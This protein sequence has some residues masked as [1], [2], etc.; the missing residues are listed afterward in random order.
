MA[1]HQ[2]K[3]IQSQLVS[4][5]NTDNNDCPDVDSDDEPEDEESLSSSAAPMGDDTTD[6]QR[7]EHALRLA[8]NKISAAYAHY[9]LPIL[10]DQLDKF[11][12]RM[13]A[14]KCKIC[15][16]FTNR[17][18]YDSSC[19]N[20]LSHVAQCEKKQQKSSKHKT[21]ASLGVSGTGDIDPQEVLQRCAVWCA[22]GAKPFSALEETSLKRVLHPTILKHLPDR[23]MVSKAIHMLYL[24]VQEKLC[25]DL[26]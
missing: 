11:K 15:L 16:K 1:Q 21:L 19:S 4:E 22:E 25:E 26:K 24:C 20:L 18:A 9:E 5:D 23:K 7:L 13:I 8:H 10:S 14:W 3:R 6:E 17:P 12:R 2:R